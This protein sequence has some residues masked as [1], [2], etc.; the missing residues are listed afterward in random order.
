MRRKRASREDLARTYAAIGVDD[1]DAIEAELDEDTPQLAVAAFALSVWHDVDAWRDDLGWVERM[2][3]GPHGP[4]DPRLRETVRRI[5]AAGITAE[6]LGLLARDAAAAA[7]F[8]V[9]SRLDDGYAADL[10]ERHG[11]RLP[12]WS[13]EEVGT[14]DRSTGRAMDFLHESFFEWEPRRVDGPEPEWFTQLKAEFD[15]GEDTGAP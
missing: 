7:A 1:E 12:R 8:S 2:A 10:E 6:E 4:R 15:A 5:L 13:L 9:M 11:V 3:D 14:D